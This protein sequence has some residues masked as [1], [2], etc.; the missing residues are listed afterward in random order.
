[1]IVEEWCFGYMWG[2]VFFDWLMLFDLLKLVLEV[3]VLYGIEENFEW[4]EKMLLE[5]F[6]ESVDVI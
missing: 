3:I 4:V 6:E 2:V 1:M 5:V